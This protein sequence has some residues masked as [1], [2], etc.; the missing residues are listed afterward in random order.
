MRRANIV[1]HRAALAAAFVVIRAVAVGT[2][3]EVFPTPSWWSPAARCWSASCC[4]GPA[5]RICRARASHA[6][7]SARA[8]RSQRGGGTQARVLRALKDLE[9]ERSV[10]K[11][12]EDDFATLSAFGRGEGAVASLDQS[13]APNREHAEQLLQQ[14]LAEAKLDE[15]PG[16]H[17][18]RKKALEPE[19]E[20]PAARQPKAKSL[21]TATRPPPPA[22]RST[23]CPSRRP[24]NQGNCAVCTPRAPTRRC[25]PARPATTWTPA[26]A[27]AAAMPWSKRTRCSAARVQLSTKD[28]S[29]LPRLRRS[30]G[31][32]M[33][34]CH[35]T[36]LSLFVLL[37][38]L[39]AGAR[40]RRPRR[41]RPHLP[42]TA[43]A[44][45]KPRPRQP[46]RPPPRPRQRTTTTVPPTSRTTPPAPR[47][48]DPEPAAKGIR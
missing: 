2:L 15:K 29:R 13:L 33:T 35:K 41:R 47:A 1:P 44:R 16:K 4:S 32:R 24:N 38:A 3:G 8:W 48:V 14:R 30:P 21:P 10:G 26:S 46:S 39:P 43:T 19:P 20:A 40:R 28:R 25:A 18:A 34:P 9:Y 45:R 27:R 17:K 5:S 11:I 31:G 42:S 12:S 36:L 22:R 6:R 7:R 23:N 37:V